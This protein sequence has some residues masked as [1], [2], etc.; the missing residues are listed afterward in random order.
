MI[1]KINLAFTFVTSSVWSSLEGNLN[2]LNDMLVSRLLI[3]SVVV[4]IAITAQMN[5]SHNITGSAQ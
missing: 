3:Y 2:A 1:P 5:L 4:K